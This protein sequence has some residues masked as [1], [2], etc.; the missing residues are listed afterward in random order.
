MRFTQ[1]DAMQLLPELL[2]GSD[3][4]AFVDPPYTVNGCGPGLRLY[5]HTQVDHERLLANLAGSGCA[6]L[7]TYHASPA[8]RRLA[9][10]HGFR[11][12]AEVMQTTHH[13]IRSELILRRSPA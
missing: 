3:I 10:K 12:S 8:I 5:R 2:R 13:Q 6:C 9:H 1:G 4:A 11:V 7:A